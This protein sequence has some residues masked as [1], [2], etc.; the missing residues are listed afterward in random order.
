MFSALRLDGTLDS[1]DNPGPVV[2]DVQLNLEAVLN[3]ADLQGLFDSAPDTV[4]SFVNF[5]LICNLISFIL[6]IRAC[7]R[8]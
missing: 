3:H 1:G 4:S 5:V 2:P 6:L 7:P 8:V